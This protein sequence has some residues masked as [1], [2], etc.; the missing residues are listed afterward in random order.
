MTTTGLKVYLRHSSLALVLFAMVL[1]AGCTLGLPTYDERLS[2]PTADDSFVVG[3]SLDPD[4]PLLGMTPEQAAEVMD[5]TWRGDVLVSNDV[6]I[7]EE[8]PCFDEPTFDG[9]SSVSLLFRC[10]DDQLDIGEGSI[11]ISSSQAGFS[12]RITSMSRQGDLLEAETVPAQLEEI[13]FVADFRQQ[14]VLDREVLE[15]Q[16]PETD[17]SARDLNINA[18]WTLYERTVDGID[19]RIKLGG[20]AALQPVVDFDVS[21]RL[22]SV[23]GIPT[24]FPC[25]DY[26]AAL[27]VVSDLEL[28]LIL[29]L[30]AGFQFGQDYPLPYTLPARPFF[31][32]V[33]PVPVHGEIN[34]EPALFWEVKAGAKAVTAVGIGAQVT[35]TVGVRG[36][37]YGIPENLSGVTMNDAHLIEPR[38]DQVISASARVGLKFKPLVD[39]Q[40][41][42]LEL[43]SQLQYYVEAKATADCDEVDLVLQHGAQTRLGISLGWGPL[44]VNTGWNLFGLGPYEIAGTSVPLEGLLTGDSDCV[45]DDDEEAAADTFEDLPHESTDSEVWFADHIGAVDQAIAEHGV[46]VPGEPGPGEP[47]LPAEG[48]GFVGVAIS[49]SGLG[50]WRVDAEGGVEANGDADFHGEPDE[51]NAVVKGLVPTSDGDGYWIYTAA[52]RVYDFG[53]ANHHNDVV[54]QEVDASITDMAPLADDRGYWL[55]DARGETHAFGAAEHHGSIED[56]AIEDLAMVLVPTATG[57]GYWIGTLLGRIVAF[58]DASEIID[59]V[60]TPALTD[61]SRLPDTNRLLVLGGEGSLQELDGNEDWSGWSD[62]GGAVSLAIT[63]SGE[64]AMVLADNG[65]LRSQGDAPAVAETP[66]P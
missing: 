17:P 41:G 24:P 13:L 65:E 63:A 52:G 37:L 29:E 16:D 30:G 44:S 8:N 32:M 1:Q 19:Y 43:S 64:G 11:V 53:S 21:L 55:L 27:S 57:D 26:S 10:A 25:G 42:S 39:L 22:C 31:F 59:E 18:N 2:V 49:P 50:Y 28:R 58:G 36:D 14:V 20:R 4:D 7:L 62:L 35:G 9:Q 48:P 15:L 38:F 12:R 66:A 60:D 23:F 34:F 54:S 56:L 45:A 33:G 46:D 40:A 47:A 6:V 3:S 51:V 61:M 5:A